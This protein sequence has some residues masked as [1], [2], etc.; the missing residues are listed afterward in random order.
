M[1]APYDLNDLQSDIGHLANLLEVVTDHF[2]EHVPFV[3]ADGNRRPEIDRLNA[4]V[5]IARDLGNGL[6][7]K[8]E[9][10][11]PAARNRGNDA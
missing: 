9:Q 5:W 2:L 6:C 11:H 3:D 8:V 4:L 7:E 1:A 10:L